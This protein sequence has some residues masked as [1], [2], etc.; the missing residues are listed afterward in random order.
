MLKYIHDSKG[1]ISLGMY[2]FAP[3]D[4]GG[5]GGGESNSGQQG[6]QQ[7]TTIVTPFDNLNLE[8][9]DDTTRAAVEKGK[10]EFIATSQRATKLDSDLQ[11]V[12]GLSRR[13][14]A[15]S[16]RLKVQLEKLNG[17]KTPESADPLLDEVTQQFRAAGY[18]EEDFNKLAPIL[19]NVIKKAGQ[20][21]REQLGRDLAPLATTVLVQEA[22]SAFQAARESNNDPLGMLQDNTVAEKVWTIVQDRISKGQ[23]TNIPIVLNLAKMQWVDEM[24]NKAAKGEAPTIPKFTPP[25]IPNMNTG[26]FTFPGA[27]SNGLIAPI[28]RHVDPNAARTNMNEDTQNALAETFANM[29]KADGIYPKA[30]QPKSK[31]GKK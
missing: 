14:Q 17:T 1:N 27:G 24:A 2:F 30:F 11:H 26:G 28:P 23:E 4:G 20:Q 9:L 15:D 6:Q 8:E 10:A 5:N 21:Q 13:F 12:T 31:G 29:G 18:K 16:D 3:D 19:S 22:T 25:T 7:Q